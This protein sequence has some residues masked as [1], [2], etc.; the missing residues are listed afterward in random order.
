[1][2]RSPKLDRKPINVRR[3]DLE[4]RSKKKYDPENVLRSNQNIWPT[5]ACTQ[6]RCANVCNAITNTYGARRSAA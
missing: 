4:R 2:R 3:T 5:L 6:T 1:M